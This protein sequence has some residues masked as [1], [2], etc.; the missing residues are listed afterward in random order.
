MLVETNVLLCAI[1]HFLVL[2]STPFLCGILCGVWIDV[3]LGVFNIFH[4]PEEKPDK[5]LHTHHFL[6]FRNCSVQ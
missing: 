1:L 4:K 3:Y 2:E 6:L 5:T